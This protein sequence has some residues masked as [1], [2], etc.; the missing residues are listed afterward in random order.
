MF[1]V[2]GDLEVS[3]VGRRLLTGGLDT[4]VAGFVETGVVFL[5]SPWSYYEPYR[6]RTSSHIAT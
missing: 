3:A 6:R 4:V 5:L 2:F 1:S